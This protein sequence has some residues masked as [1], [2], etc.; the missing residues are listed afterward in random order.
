MK[1]SELKQL[2]REILK[3]KARSLDETKGLSGMKKSPEKADNT[4]MKATDKS[5][6][7]T[8]EPKGKDEGKKLPVKDSKSNTETDHLAPKKS[9]PTP[10]S[11][12]KEESK[13]RPV[14]GHAA[15]NEGILDSYTDWHFFVQDMAILG[16][17]TIIVLVG[18]YLWLSDKVKGVVRRFVVKTLG[19]DFD[20]YCQRRAEE[21]KKDPAIQQALADPKHTGLRKAIERQLNQKDGEMNKIA[22]KA[23]GSGI[24]QG[25][26]IKM[27]GPEKPTTPYWP[28]PGVKESVSIKETILAMIREEVDEYRTKGAL[29]AKNTARTAPVKATGL[30]YVAKNPRAGAEAEPI[31]LE[32]SL[33]NDIDPNKAEPVDFDFLNNT[34]GKARS[35]IE[36]NI[37]AHLGADALSAK[38]SPEVYAAIEKGKENDLDGKLTTQNNKIVLYFDKAT[39]QLRVKNNVSETYHPGDED[40]DEDQGYDRNDPKHPTWAERNAEKADRHRDQQRDRDAEKALNSKVNELMGTANSITA[41]IDNNVF[42]HTSDEF[43]K[44]AEEQGLRVKYSGDAS[45]GTESLRSYQVQL[46]GPAEKINAFVDSI[47]QEKGIDFT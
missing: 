1:K 2:I 28:E 31:G 21:L 40:E 4:Q 42:P 17:A 43:E 5:I 35:F 33:A 13:V 46:S 32:V 29:G 34:Q 7:S 19:K 37:M 10:P 36:A 26:K 12:E 38:V 9:T 14:G 27:A 39:K 23:L 47:S 30:N 6:T 20:E 15:V 45:F 44:M 22:Q 16:A 25:L 8:A 24:V 18:G 41:H 11:N 3:Q